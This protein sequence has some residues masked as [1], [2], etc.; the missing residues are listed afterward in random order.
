MGTTVTGK[1]NKAATQFQAGESVGFGVRIGVKYYDRELKADAWTNYEA[2]IF[3]KAP[4]Q[5]QFYQSVLVEGSVIEL[6]GTKQRIRQY[7][8]TNGLQLSIEILDAQ[9][10]VAYSP[11]VPAMQPGQ[12]QPQQRPQQQQQQQGYAQQPQQRPAQQP[13]NQPAHGKA[14]NGS[15]APNMYQGAPQQQGYGQQPQQQYNHNPNV[16]MVNG[17][18]QTMDFSDDIPF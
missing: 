1:L 13:Y 2:V 14:A 10:G 4:A 9:L 6:T 7:Q 3:A 8:G 11:P 17:Q 16:A 18:P 12:P 5:V 15:A